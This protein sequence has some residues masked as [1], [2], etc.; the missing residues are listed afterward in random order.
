MCHQYRLSVQVQDMEEE[1]SEE[2]DE[3][4]V[5]V[6]AGSGKK[7]PPVPMPPREVQQPPPLPPTPDKVVVKKGYDPKQ[8]AA[9]IP[10]PL[11]RTSLMSASYFILKNI[12]LHVYWS[13]TNN[14]WLLDWIY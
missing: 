6:S 4:A 10:L 5:P 9:I 1:S 7:A 8:G 13:V 11:F 14:L 12:L 3:P 2:E